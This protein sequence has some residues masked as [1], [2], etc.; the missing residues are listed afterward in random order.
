MNRRKNVKIAIPV[1]GL[2]IACLLL[3]F[4]CGKKEKPVVKV[5]EV[6]ITASDVQRV[7]GRKML[8]LGQDKPTEKDRQ[9]A[10][11]ALIDRKLLLAEAGRRGLTSKEEIVAA[12]MKKSKMK[13]ANEAAF[14]KKLK[15]EGLSFDGFRRE[16]EENLVIQQ[17]E[18]QL[19]SGIMANEKEA[20][21]YYQDNL[22]EFS[23]PEQF[24]VYLVLVADEKNAGHILLKA[25]A[26]PENFDRM[27][28]QEM[29]PEL[30]QV[31]RKAALTP[32]SDFPEQMQPLLEKMKIGQ[33]DGP[34][35][36]KKGYFLFR[37]IDRKPSHNKSWDQVRVDLLHL[38]TQEKR[39]A[40]VRQWLAE[41][42]KIVK[43][44]MQ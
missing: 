6:Q 40:A 31:N 9:D 24:K 28:L 5:G 7:V 19:S 35:K 25:K 10:L 36:T 16:I 30:Q 12:E 21:K 1:V 43:V 3:G 8:L 20:R 13:F 32:K 11:E 44:Q 17:V 27:A 26:S 39:Q 42:R 22:R 14:N 38:L 37:L 2:M 18:E 41:Q 34:V 15:D 23:V 4:G 33:V 29:K